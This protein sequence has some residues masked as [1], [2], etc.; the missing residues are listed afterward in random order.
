MREK[1]GL[2]YANGMTLVELEYWGPLA[3]EYDNADITLRMK[4]PSEDSC[5]EAMALA[6]QEAADCIQSRLRALQQAAELN[7]PQ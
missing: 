6:L 3:G 4:I 5:A 7:Q 1:V 2:T